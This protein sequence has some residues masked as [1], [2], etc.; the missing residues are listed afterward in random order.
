M[1]DTNKTT[2]HPPVMGNGLIRLRVNERGV[3]GRL[4]AYLR[5]VP[6]GEP[7]EISQHD[8]YVDLP[9]TRI[10]HAKLPTE[11]RIGWED[12]SEASAPLTIRSEAEAANLAGQGDLVDVKVNFTRGQ[13]RG[14]ARNPINGLATPMIIGR[15]NGGMMRQV[16]TEVVSANP[17]GGAS[18]AFDM[19]VD[20][21][22]FTADG[23]T[24]ELL[25]APSMK[26]LW[27]YGLGPVGDAQQEAI[28]LLR[29][30]TSLEHNVR[31][32]VADI[33][34]RLG[35]RISA[36]SQLFEDVVTYLLALIH[37]RAASQKKTSGDPDREMARAL[38]NKS[39]RPPAEATAN[40]I[41]VVGVAS[42]F[43]GQ[44]WSDVLLTEHRIEVRRFST[45]ATVLN[46]YPHRPVAKIVVTLV[47][48]STDNIGQLHALFDAEPAQINVAGVAAAP[49][50]IVVT[51]KLIQG[52]EPET[53]GLLT[54][55]SAEGLSPVA[56]QDVRFHYAD[57][58]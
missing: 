14:T 47:E 54:L 22:D 43:M 11:I 33:E 16:R 5:G 37:D 24:I 42:P 55:I 30:A 46:P 52:Q 41:A 38:L 50:S 7:T 36:Q 56:V 18:I 20:A 40:Q 21:N 15:I 9:V 35:L 53:I 29:Q 25:L 34:T 19:P 13:V 4:C 44:G 45:A 2:F 3:G 57:I 32:A 51:S 10:P 39:V 28:K 26:T 1:S 23:G 49:C 27:R 8:T 6:L 31:G 58:L 48:G 17:E 12:S